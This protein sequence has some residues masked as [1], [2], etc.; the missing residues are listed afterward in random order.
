[1]FLISE[2]HRHKNFEDSKAAVQIASGVLCT[3]LRSVAKRLHVD[4]KVSC[5]STF[6]CLVLDRDEEEEDCQTLS[7]KKIT[8]ALDAKRRL[9]QRYARRNRRLPQLQKS[10]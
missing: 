10:P 1:M 5:G 7:K 4:N 2:V 3:E 8:S 9:L 6:L